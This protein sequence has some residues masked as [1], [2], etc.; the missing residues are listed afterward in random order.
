MNMRLLFFFF[1][2]FLI[3]EA[4]AQTVGINY[5]TSIEQKAKIIAENNDKIQVLE[6]ELLNGDDEWD[7]KIAD[8]KKAI[9]DLEK[10]RDE[11]LEEMK[12]GARCSKCK[13][14]KTEIEAPGTETFQQHLG[15]VNGYAIPASESELEVVRIKY[16][17]LIAYQRVLLKNTEKLNPATK[18]K[19]D[20]EKMKAS[21]VTLC[22]EITALSKS[23]ETDVFASAKQKHKSWFDDVMNAIAAQHIAMDGKTLSTLLKTK[24]TTKFNS[25]LAE[26][27]KRHKVE[28]DNEKQRLNNEKLRLKQ[29]QDDLLSDYT[30]NKEIKE[31]KRNEISQSIQNL[32]I[33]LNGSAS[34]SL[35]QIV[36]GQLDRERSELAIVNSELSKLTDDYNK[37][38]NRLQSDI[39][40]VDD[41]LW[42]LQ[43]KVTVLQT[44]HV[45][46][47]ATLTFSFERKMDD[48]KYRL[49]QADADITLLTSKVLAKKNEY[50]TANIVYVDE[51]VKECNRMLIAVQP[52]GCF[53]YNEIRFM[54]TLNYNSQ[55]SCVV[56]LTAGGMD[57]TF[58]SS[59]LACLSK[60]PA[61]VSS[62]KSFAN[63]LSQEQIDAIK[64]ATFYSWYNAILSN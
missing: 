54:V 8:A 56:T 23:Y 15:T 61:Y 27:K 17:E 45:Q 55:E 26:M 31:L 39:L 50:K 35:K 25:D 63:G 7:K 48:I 19:A 1:G 51:I 40:D 12:A 5:V 14:W 47:I 33:Q 28:L 46:E 21:N 20:I 11:R 6:T 37:Y 24:Y 18:K 60:F 52:I 22:S 32:E 38:N 41:E 42:K 29:K 44:T 49:Y 3:G 58:P 4:S 62:Y 2:L 13:L 16:R 43:T 53:V 57:R 9:S 34:D 59:G 36:Q 10:E 30:S 64:D